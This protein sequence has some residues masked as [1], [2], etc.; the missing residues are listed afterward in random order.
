[1]KQFSTMKYAEGLRG[2]AWGWKALLR[3]VSVGSL[4]FAGFADSGPAFAGYADAW[5]LALLRSVSASSLSF[6]GFLGLKVRRLRFFRA[7]LAVAMFFCGSNLFAQRL[8]LTDVQSQPVTGPGPGLRIALGGTVDS[9]MSV[10]QRDNRDYPQT[11]INP[12]FATSVPF[13]GTISYESIGFNPGFRFDFA[14]GYRLNQW[15]N[16]EFE[17][18]CIYN[19]VES[20]TITGNGTFTGVGGNPNLNGTMKLYAQGYLLQ[21]PLMV[22]VEFSYPIGDGWRPFIG[23]G[24]GGMFQKLTVSTISGTINYQG[25]FNQ[26]NFMGAWEAFLGCGYQVAPGFDVSIA[27]RVDGVLSPDFGGYTMQNFF[28]Q[29]AEF[30]MNWRF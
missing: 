20:Y 17:T 28:T 8:S 19:T 21:V 11:N 10:A 7:C 6:A 14:P 23:A 15:I 22:N 13:S 24:G 9:D 18:G 4:S 1:M 25:D 26:S 5:V 16:F 29:A 30:E 2:L 12:L 27:Y 3:S